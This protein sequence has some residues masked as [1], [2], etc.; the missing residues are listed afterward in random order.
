MTR[1]TVAIKNQMINKALIVAGINKEL[2]SLIERRA[3]LAN[4]I[5]IDSLGG[6]DNI[7]KIKKHLKKISNLTESDLI[8]N[9]SGRFS[10]YSHSAFELNHINLG[11]MRV[12]LQYSGEVC[13]YK[14][15]DK[16]V[17]H[18]IVPV[19]ISVVY[20]ADSEFTKEFIEIEGDY[21]TVCGKKEGMAAQVKAT[22]NQFTTV[23]KLL[24]AWPEAKDLIP[25]DVDEV[26]PKLPVVQVQDL[27]CLIGLPEE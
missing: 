19:D 16:R 26:K 20:T 14:D 9:V 11:G 21:K 24:E 13:G 7:T 18:E 2:K 17:S 22:L 23:K 27:N 4:S 10:S 15:R 25:D 6:E 5:R 12:T 1:L 8:K 3:L